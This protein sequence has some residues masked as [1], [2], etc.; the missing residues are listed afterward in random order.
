MLMASLRQ[1]S[2]AIVTHPAEQMESTDYHQVQVWERVHWILMLETYARRIAA[3]A[4][5]PHSKGCDFS[6]VGMNS[7]LL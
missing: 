5:S 4:I 1:Q 2:G 3:I 6:W 7:E